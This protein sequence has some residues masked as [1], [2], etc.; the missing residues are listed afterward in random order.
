MVLEPRKYLYSTSLRWSQE[1]KGILSCE[2][3]PD[4]PVACPPEW[5]GHPGIWSP[6]DLFVASVEVCTMT[7]FLFLMEKYRGELGSYRS[8]AEGTVQMVDNVFVFKSVTVK[9]DVKVP[10]DEDARK[11]ARAFSELGDL[12]LVTKMVRCAINVEPRI[13][14][15]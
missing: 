15:L 6:E 2:G 11:A 12:C 5:G 14:L 13:S 3:K 10:T 7:T 4:I 8:S 9:S 1:H